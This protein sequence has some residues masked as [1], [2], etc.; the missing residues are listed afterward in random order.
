MHIGL[1]SIPFIGFHDTEGLQDQAMNTLEENEEV[2]RLYQ[3]E[4]L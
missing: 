4:V 2:Q 3:A 1:L